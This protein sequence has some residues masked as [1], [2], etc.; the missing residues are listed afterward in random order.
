MTLS[1][2]AR[3]WFGK[4]RSPDERLADGSGRPKRVTNDLGDLGR[5][6]DGSA[7]GVQGGLRVSAQGD[8]GFECRKQ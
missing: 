6:N 8:R 2:L 1:K 7:I 5:A 4:L 3:S